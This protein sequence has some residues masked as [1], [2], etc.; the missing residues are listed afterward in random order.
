MPR[1]GSLAFVTAAIVAAAI[2]SRAQAQEPVDCLSK[3]NDTYQSAVSECQAE[4]GDPGEKMQ[5]QQCMDA[6][7]SSLDRCTDSCDSQD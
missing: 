2:A 1:S 3:C 4:L 7:Q 5:L 6:A